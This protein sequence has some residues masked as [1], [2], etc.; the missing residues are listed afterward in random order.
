MNENIKIM[1]EKLAQD[2]ET[3]KKLSAVR[4]P[5]EAYAIVTAIHGGYTKEEFVETMKALNEQLNQDLDEKDLATASGGLDG[6]Q[7][8]SVVKTV[9]AGGVSTAVG[10]YLA[11]TLSTAAFSGAMGVVGATSAAV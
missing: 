3:Q 10:T 9:I 11:G 4:D 2:E 7:L 6:E 5:D 1:L 8:G